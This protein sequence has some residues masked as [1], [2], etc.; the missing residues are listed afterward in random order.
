M[1]TQKWTSRAVAR[2]IEAGNSALCASCGDAVQF[3]A[4]VKVQQ[5][6]CNVYVDGKWDRVEHFHRDCYD[7]AGKPYGEADES[8]P[9]RPKNRQSSAA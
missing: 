5:V 3:R 1:A 9:L 8:Q 4:R 6:I 2:Y 7:E